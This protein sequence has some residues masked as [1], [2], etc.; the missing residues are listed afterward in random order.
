MRQRGASEHPIK[1]QRASRRKASKPLVAAI[2]SIADLQHQIG[3]LTRELHEAREQQ[4]ATT[5]VLKVIN[6]SPG[7][8]EP[9]FSAMLEKATQLCEAAFGILWLCGGE[10]FRAAALHGVPA[11]YVEIARKPVRPLPTNP[12]GRL[13]RG[14]R[15]IVSTDVADEEP[16]RTGDPVRRALVDLGG[17]RSVIQVALVKDDG[18]LGSLTVYRQEVRPFSD[19]Q[20]ALLQNFA[21]QAV[22]AIE[23]ARLLNELR[24]RTADL[25]EALEQRTATSEVLQ[26]I[27]S[28]PG[29]TEPVFT[30]I[31]ENASRICEAKFGVL[32]LAQGD[33]FRLGAAHNAPQA[34]AE[35]MLRGLVQPNPQITFGRAV[36]T[37]QVAQT[38]DITIE[39]PY[40]QGDPL[41]VAAA[42]LGGYRTVLAV[43]MLKESNVIGALVFFRQEVRAF[44]DKQ[45]ALVQN[46]AAQAVIAIENARLLGE[47]RQRT[48]DLEGSLEYQ[49]AI[50]DVLKIISRSTFDLQPVLETVARTAGRLCEAE[51]AFLSQREGDAFRY[52]AA[53]GST[54]EAT[55][56]AVR[57]RRYLE[58]HPI[59]ATPDRR[60]MTGRVMS[61]RR[62]VQIADITA[63]PEYQFPETFKLA[64]IRAVL[65]VPLLR[66]GEPIGVMSLARQRPEPF[67]ERQIELVRTFADQAVIAIEN[68]RLLIE[69]R[70]ALERQ[71]ATA[72]VLEVINSSPGNLAPVFDTILL[73]AHRLCGVAYGS[74]QV[75]DGEWFRAVAVHDLP[76]Q[77]ANLLRRGFRAS[78]HPV[79][80]ALLGG[81]RLVHLD[82]AQID[83]P[84]MRGA[85][86]LAGI[87]TALFVPLRRD[88]TLL[89][90]IVSGRRE[91]KPFTENDIALLEGFAAQ[92]VIAIENARLLTET[93]EALERQ[94]ATAEILKVI[95]S[96]PSNVQPVFAAIV[97]S[98]ARLFEPCAATITTL[99]DG[100]LHW[101]AT[102]ALLPGFNVELT[103]AIYPLPFDPV[104][105]P[106]ARATLERRVIEIPDVEAPDTPEF[107]RNAAAAGGFGSITF[108]PLIDQ[109]RG[110]GTIIFTHRDKGFRFSPKQLA[111]VQTFA[112]QAVIA[113]QNARL[114]NDT[115]EALERQTATADILKVIASTPSD[116][117]PVFDAIA[118]RAKSLLGGFSATVF[119]FVDG[120]SHL[121]AFTPTT[122][123]ADEILKSSFPRPVVDFA[124][125][126]MV[127][128]GDVTQVPDTEAGTHEL[129][130]IARARGYRSML[131][132]PLMNKGEAIGF[133]SV[134]RVQPGSFADHHVQLLQTFADQAVIAIQNAQLFNEL[135]HRTRDLSESLQQQTATADVLK[136][137][138]RSTFDLQKVLDTLTESA[139]RLCEAYDAA[140]F[141]REGDFLRLGAHNGP[142]PID[143]D[144]SPISRQWVTGRSAVDCRPVHVHDLQAETSEFP[145]GSDMARRLGHRTI[146]AVPLMRKQEVIGSLVVR[147]TEVRP[148]TKQQIALVETF[149]DQA[150]IAIENARL[151]SELRERQA[152]LRTTFDNMGDG[153][154]MFDAAARLAAWNRNLQEMLDLQ[155][156]FLAQRPSLSELF[157]YLS[158]RGEFGSG[159]LEAQLGRSL[160]DT[161]QEMRYERTRPDGRVM[162]VRRNPVPDGGF[163]LIYADITERKHAEEAIRAARDA[164]ETALRELQ[165][166]QDRLV[167]TQKLALLGQLTAGIAHEI[168][169]P[170]NFVNNF[171]SLSVEL[172][173]EL[174]E[175][176]RRVRVDDKTRAEI[177]ELA[178]TLRDNLG[179]IVQH[180][181]RADSIVKNM[182]LHSRHG[183]GE[184]R[185]ADINAL[186]EE[187][188]NLA[189]HG[190]RAEKPGFNITLERDLDPTAATVEM[191]PQEV[192]RVFLNLISNGFYA[193]AKRKE[194]AGDGFEP[195]LRATTRNLG[196][197]IEIR[198]RDNGAGIP[199]E[200]KES[201]FNPFFT[202]KP[203]GEGT[204][205]GLSICHDIIV[206]QHG[207]RIDVATD[208]GAFTE[209]IVTLPQTATAPLQT[210]GKS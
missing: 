201:I 204:G 29:E 121:K 62:A 117:Q 116:A 8:L 191:Y 110:I 203:A 176:L 82:C 157:R 30:A 147:R 81:A 193:A 197:A 111:L 17:A 86:E 132:A 94:T 164:A 115:N 202:T 26:I 188:L 32:M 127:R 122:P 24:Q 148:F 114:F 46:F 150:V 16:Y 152:E 187:S 99:K 95:A 42:E 182:L 189:Y 49:T 144:K 55:A 142:I 209:F 130:D 149:A 141:V 76:E 7:Q 105:S 56:D 13:L 9:V 103:R 60:T 113:I 64:K 15:V 11:A 53:V 71:T 92:A 146:F 206:K 68:T 210:G 145:V 185:P 165:T 136:A 34:F 52:V 123:E 84:V 47:L 73:K 40:L 28:S 170:L 128:A 168:K 125:F 22:I 178:D 104:R 154:A 196:S 137:I 97:N 19:T 31:L 43:P 75:Y 98:G 51:M 155:E 171:S 89:G 101:N 38:A 27:S 208:P 83:H 184:R 167:Q 33:A 161:R 186:V 205:L 173:D 172:I 169:N 135:E 20:V 194:A 131:F 163:V 36:A 1:G 158:A 151:L 69:Q 119:L 90:M 179:K 192:T 45:I 78:D 143:F 66:D 126:R 138:S 80:G 175:D 120:M 107:T 200:V 12:L 93:R 133:I 106:S 118:A 124:A 21:S 160:E 195:T 181:K 79:G 23:N 54:P 140:L 2:P 65:G 100:M 180:G 91:V 37:K 58:T 174:Q 67:T 48:N 57:F 199:P 74:L 108:V 41:A 72:E 87:R 5:E 88:E 14:E 18:L 85:V 183:S 177:T 61:E 39:Q 77:F 6:S 96:S 198:I 129:R 159:D 134:T 63:D 190:A 44:D 102:A 4:I 35:F 50:G 207:G 10:Q 112:D 162:E 156:V 3:T 139:C 153:V 25:T 166:A 59:S 70:E 109:D